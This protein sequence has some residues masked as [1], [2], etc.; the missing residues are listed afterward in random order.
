MSGPRNRKAFQKSCRDREAIRLA[1]LEHARAHP[2][3]RPPTARELRRQLG[4]RASERRIQ[5]HMLS[6]RTAAEIRELLE[7]HLSASA[8]EAAPEVSP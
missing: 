3:S 7:E 4:L 5:Q 2:L 8:P 1:L 6:L